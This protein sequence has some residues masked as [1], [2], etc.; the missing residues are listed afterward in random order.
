MMKWIAFTT[1]NQPISYKLPLIFQQ[2]PAKT[3]GHREVTD[4]MDI[5]QHKL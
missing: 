3:W 4:N 1:C 5:M 2:E